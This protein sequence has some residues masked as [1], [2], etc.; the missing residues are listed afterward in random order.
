MSDL[1]DPSKIE[2]IVGIA[3]HDYLHYARVVSASSRVYILHS[4][5]CVKAT[6]DLRDCPYSIAL[7]VRRLSREDWTPE[8]VNRPVVIDIDHGDGHLIPDPYSTESGR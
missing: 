4:S 6:E 1:V 8:Y 5:V 7:D 2:R 3:R